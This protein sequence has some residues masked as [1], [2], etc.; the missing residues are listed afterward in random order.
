[1]PNECHL[2]KG[3]R[4]VHGRYVCFCRTQ[5]RT[6]LASFTG[7]AFY[8][9][10]SQEEVQQRFETYNGNYYV[11]C[12]CRIIRLCQ[13]YGGEAVYVTAL[14]VMCLIITAIISLPVVALSRRITEFTDRISPVQQM[15]KARIAVEKPTT[16]KEYRVPIT[17]RVASIDSHFVPPVDTSGYHI[18]SV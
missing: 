5:I 9:V 6:G 1:M 8:L 7:Y 10:G 12:G 4:R 3:H 16:P 17:D 2:C 11:G 15:P 18:T 13:T 14:G